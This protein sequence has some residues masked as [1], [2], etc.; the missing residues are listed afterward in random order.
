MSV[1]CPHDTTSTI[2]R[3]GSS[4]RES[5]DSFKFSIGEDDTYPTMRERSASTL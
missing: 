1:A 5:A 4:T 2:A 3:C